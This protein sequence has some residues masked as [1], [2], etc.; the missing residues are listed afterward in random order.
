MEV[1]TT[2]NLFKLVLGSD[3]VRLWDDPVLSARD[4]GGMSLAQYRQKPAFQ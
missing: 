4:Q 3:I 2:A 1:S